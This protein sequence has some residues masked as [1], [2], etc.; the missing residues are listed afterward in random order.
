LPSYTDCIIIVSFETR[1][2]RA[3][4]PFTLLSITLL[5]SVALMSCTFYP[6]E[7]KLPS[8]LA[9]AE[10][11]LPSNL[12]RS[13]SQHAN[14][15]CMPFD[16]LDMYVKGYRDGFM[17]NLI[18]EGKAQLLVNYDGDRAWGK[19]YEQGIV[20]SRWFD[21][22]VTLVDFGYIR[23]TGEGKFITGFEHATFYPANS[24]ERWWYTNPL[25]LPLKDNQDCIVE[26]WITPIGQHGHMGRYQRT[27][28][29][30]SIVAVH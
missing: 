28:I 1:I 19:G 22:Q 17:A 24:K 11:K 13:A 23:F 30:T 3:F 9:R 8:N 20:D 5:G 21:T 29:I 4:R 14:A 26:G 15:I 10:E 7:E 18:R 6:T 2:M 27:F 25:Q 16:G 12:A